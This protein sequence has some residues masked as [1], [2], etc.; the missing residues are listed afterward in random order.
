[1]AD[2]PPI[3]WPPPRDR[4]DELAVVRSWLRRHPMRVLDCDRAPD[5][6]VDGGAELAAILAR[7]RAAHD[8]APSR[9]RSAGRARGRR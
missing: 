7:L 5:E 4:A 8:D 9:P 1:V 6:P 3:G 2:A